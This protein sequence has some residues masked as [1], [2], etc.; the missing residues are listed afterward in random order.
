MATRSMFL[1]TII[2]SLLLIQCDNTPLR[3]IDIPELKNRPFTAEEIQLIQSS[4]TF[5][6]QIFKRLSEQEIPNKKNIFISPLSISINL[7]MVL[8][9]ARA[10]TYDAIYKT[11]QFQNMSLEAINTYS[12]SLIQL[13][14]TLDPAVK[15]QTAN[16]LFYRKGFPIKSPFKQALERYY[17][18]HIAALDFASPLA[19]QT[20]NNWVNI[21]THGLIPKIIDQISKE[22]M[23]FLINAIYFKGMWTY[24]FSAS[25]TKDRPFFLDTG[26][27]ISVPTMYRKGIVFRAKTEWGTIIDLPYGNRRFHM[28]IFLPS[29]SIP[30]SRVIQQLTKETIETYFQELDSIKVNLYLP[31][32]RYN[33]STSLNEILASMGMGIAFNPNQVDFSGIS[34]RKLVISQVNHSATVHVDEK[35]TEAAAV[36]STEL[37]VVSLPPTIAVNRPFLFLIR[38]NQAN[39]ILFMGMVM[40]PAP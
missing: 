34:N 19:I 11:L 14:M 24:P 26:E 2:F 35:G 37:E 39:T 15:F 16:S 8:N 5:A 25:E 33:F 9:G 6:I 1:I 27:E 29:N 10:K 22:T 18:A 17:G 23:L 21:Q 36:T 28:T 30:L 12:Q 13:L 3:P 38:E 20:I 7:S 31:K 40:H 4:N 32:F